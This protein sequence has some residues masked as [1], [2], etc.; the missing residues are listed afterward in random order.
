[1]LGLGNS[2]ISGGAPAAD[3][4][5]GSLRL[6]GVGDFMNLRSMNSTMNNT[7]T[8]T[9][10]MKWD[11][12]QLTGHQISGMSKFS[13]SAGTIYM[14]LL[15]TAKSYSW[16]RVN[17]QTASNGA[18][19]AMFTESNG[20]ASPW[21]TFGMSVVLDTGG[22]KSGVRHYTQGSSKQHVYNGN[23]LETTSTQNFDFGTNE[24]FIGAWCSQSGGNQWGNEGGLIAEVAVWKGYAFSEAEFDYIHNNPGV[25][26]RT[27]SGAANLD[28]Y[29]RFGE[30]GTAN[31]I[32]GGL[33][34]IYAGDPTVDTEH[35]GD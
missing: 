7:F 11:N 34:P 9:Y 21:V 33:T 18:P 29:F 5:P 4:V 8:L 14:G 20:V 16:F 2:L 30:H 28:S 31:L 6:D 27:L 17:N 25:D 32:S 24:M 10:K 3:P 15:N 19:G 22:G 12:S 13:S 26:Y 1:M 35:P 23:S